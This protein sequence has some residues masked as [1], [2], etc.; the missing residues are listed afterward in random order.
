M[1]RTDL[2]NNI[3][4][5]QKLLG[6]NPYHAANS[7]RKHLGTNYL[8]EASD[9]NLAAFYTHLLGVQEAVAIRAGQ[10]T[11]IEGI[12]V[13]WL[14][15]KDKLSLDGAAVDRFVKKLRKGLR[16]SNVSEE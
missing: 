2:L 8:R 15:E 11:L 3:E 1:T 5:Q 14:N 16:V 13:R 7:R 6:R 12:I 9:E 10:D 4:S